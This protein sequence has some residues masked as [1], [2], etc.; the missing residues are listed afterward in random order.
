VRVRVG[1]RAGVRVRMRVRFRVRVRVRGHP[2]VAPRLGQAWSLEQVAEC[3]GQVA[4]GHTPFVDGQ[5]R[6]R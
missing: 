4:V 5:R 3:D 2:I 6:P 1:V